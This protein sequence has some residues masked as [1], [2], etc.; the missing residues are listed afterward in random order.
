MN[1][2][3]EQFS[4]SP[5]E[6]AVNPWQG[7]NHPFSGATGV[8]DFNPPATIKPGWVHP[9][10]KGGDQAAL[11]VTP[12]FAPGDSGVSLPAPVQQAIVEGKPIRFSSAGENAAAKREPD[13][14]LTPE[15]QMVPNPKATPSPDGS[16]NIEIQNAEAAK[17]ESLKEAIMHQSDM[18]KKAAEEMIRLFQKAHPG[19]PVPAWMEALVNK[20]PNL[21]SFVPFKPAVEAPVAPPPENGF[22]NRG[23]SSGGFGGGGGGGARDGGYSGF[24]GNGGFDGNG[25]FKG[26]GGA[27]DG[28]ISTGGTGSSGEP[29]G[30]GEK[31]QA[32]QLYDFFVEKGFT[33][34]QA[35]GILGNIQ[36]E[37]SFRTDAYNGNENAIG[38]CQWQGD[39]R[40]KLEAF[41]QD[42]G[43]PVT[44]WRVQAE[45][46]IHELNTTETKAMAA[47]KAAET[48]EQA[49]VAFQSKYERSASIGNR[50]ELASNIHNQIAQ[51]A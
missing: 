21:P 30:Q 34:A 42:Q 16:I 14:Y 31:V 38:L 24:A 45:F 48:P 43:K 18:Q 29:L 28:S 41:A 7:S 51:N 27:G 49:A 5:Q 11:E 15:G 37:S 10:F 32:K 3:I 13:F 19:Q 8:Q 1:A 26:N 35:S 17:N 12:I 23:V 44:D 22:V 4:A 46:I 25:Y 50:R 2:H 6:N 33:P 20:E 40:T 47:L 36:A 9:A 39:R